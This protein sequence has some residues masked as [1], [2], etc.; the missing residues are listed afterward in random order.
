MHRGAHAERAAARGHRDAE[1]IYSGAITLL[2]RLP[3][4]EHRLG[5]PIAQLRAIDFRQRLDQNEEVCTRWAPAPFL[6]ADGAGRN[7]HVN[8]RMVVELSPPSVQHGDES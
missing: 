8:V 4:I 5:L 7:D 3:R 2:V 6:F 1:K